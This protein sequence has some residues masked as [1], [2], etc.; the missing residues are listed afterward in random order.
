V[1]CQESKGALPIYSVSNNFLLPTFTSNYLHSGAGKL[2]IL[3]DGSEDD[4]EGIDF[5]ALET[6]G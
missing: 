1:A 3:Q 6:A 4:L 2:L 5:D